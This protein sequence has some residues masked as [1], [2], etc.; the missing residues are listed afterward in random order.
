MALPQP[1]PSITVAVAVTRTERHVRGGDGRVY[2]PGE[3]LLRAVEKLFLERVRVAQRVRLVLCAAG[4]RE[5]P[6]L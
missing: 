6:V 1:R 4:A 2:V 3:P 5:L